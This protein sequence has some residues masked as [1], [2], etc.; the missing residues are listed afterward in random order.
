MTLPVAR[1]PVE[2]IRLAAEEILKIPSQ[3]IKLAA[4]RVVCSSRPN[5][6]ATA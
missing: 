3:K 2:S 6:L 1:R 5:K 4:A